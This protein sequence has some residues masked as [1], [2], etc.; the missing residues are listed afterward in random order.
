MIDSLVYSLEERTRSR[1]WPDRWMTIPEIAAELDDWCFWDS[2]GLAGW[3]AEGRESW[4]RRALATEEE[5]GRAIWLRMGRRYKH[6][7]LVRQ[8]RGDLDDYLTWV[9]E[10]RSAR[11]RHAEELLAGQ[12]IVEAAMLHPLAPASEECLRQAESFSA[13]VI[14]AVP[15]LRMGERLRKIWAIYEENRPTDLM[16]GLHVCRLFLAMGTVVVEAGPT[17]EV[18]T[19]RRVIAAAESWLNSLTYVAEVE[20][21]IASEGEVRPG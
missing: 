18:K 16:V 9:A 2:A 8:N 10:Q 14:D 6:F 11:A 1:V 4:L 3:S 21:T 20:D 12:A 5:D 17:G 7:A 19:L 13:G 15:D